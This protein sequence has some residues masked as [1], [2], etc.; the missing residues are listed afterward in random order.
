M[1][2]TEDNRLSPSLYDKLDESKAQTRLITIE[3]ASDA[4]ALD[5]RC[6]LSVVS[7]HDELSYIALSYVWGD[8]TVTESIL[9][10]SIPLPV[11]TNL[12]SALRHL[13]ERYKEEQIAFWID[14]I[15]INQQDEDERGSQVKMMGDIY[16]RAERVI[17]WLGKADADSSKLFALLNS[18]TGDI[19]ADRNWTEVEQSREAI[20]NLFNRPYWVRM[21]TQQEGILARDLLF[22]CGAESAP[23]ENVSKFIR[24]C[25]YLRENTHRHRELKLDEEET[26]D[27][28]HALNAV[29]N[30]SMIAL[31]GIDRNQEL[32]I[33]PDYKKDVA[34]V[35]AEFIQQTLKKHSCLVLN[36]SNGIGAVRT[37]Q[38]RIPG[39]PS[40][41]PDFTRGSRNVCDRFQPWD[42]PVDCKPEAVFSK[43]GLTLT[44]KG[45]IIDRVNGYEL[46]QAEDFYR[47]KWWALACRNGQKSTYPTGIPRIQAYFRTLIFAKP[48]AGHGDDEEEFFQLAVGF[49]LSMMPLTNEDPSESISGL[50][51]SGAFEQQ[52]FEIR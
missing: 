4:D 31:L 44:A 7:M 24:V 28:H 40:W 36:G 30:C 2:I 22:V 35:Y 41:V 42:T 33:E 10:N 39:L 51:E 19:D 29:L 52:Q 38:E 8:P 16:S 3:K 26:W 48:G 18:E 23:A 34:K 13:R 37:N 25:L 49:M 32:G 50:K 6:R 12:A 15:C 21:W 27:L 20:K 5:I 11:T 1:A 17:A 9:V 14:A 43:D 47:R 46:E 45:L